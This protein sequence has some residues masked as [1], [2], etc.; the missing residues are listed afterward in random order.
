MRTRRRRRPAG[1]LRGRVGRFPPWLLLLLGL[2]LGVSAVLVTQLISKRWGSRD[3]LAGLVQ[4]A[5]RPKPAEE[6]KPEPPA[7][8][9][10]R[11]KL[12]FYTVLPEMETVLPDR[13]PR[14]T[15]TAKAEK[16][17]DGVRYVLQAGSF[18]SFTDA[19]QLKARLALQGLVARIQKVTIEGRG[20]FHRVRLGPYSRVEQ[21]DAADQQLR[22]LGLKPIRLKLKP[23]AAG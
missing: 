14:D 2:A 19:D 22:T 23:E 10:A 4:S 1:A 8:P 11:P 5:A 17:E 20:D 7:A 21:L 18:A 16:A 13:S 12:D 9:A 6:K 3:G 15:R